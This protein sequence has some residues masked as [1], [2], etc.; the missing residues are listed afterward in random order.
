MSAYW[1]RRNIKEMKQKSILILGSEGFIGRHLVQ[2]FR[3]Q[4]W[5]VFGCDL[6]EAPSQD[7]KYQKVS[8]LSPELDDVFSGTYYFTCI[9]AAG[10][11]NVNYSMTHPVNDFEANCLDTIRVL[12][13]IK[14]YQNECRYLHFSSAAVYGNPKSLPV[15]E[16]HETAPLSPYGWHKVISE[17]LCKEYATIYKLKT[18]AVRPFSIY[19][20]GL[21]KQLLWDLYKKCMSRTDQDVQLWGTGN[22]SRDFLF[23]YDLIK[24]IDILVHEGDFNGGVYNVASG[25][26]TSIRH[27]TN[28][29]TSLFDKGIRITFNQQVREGDPI[30]W[31]ADITKIKSHNFKPQY[32][33]EQGLEIVVEWMKNLK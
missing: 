16:E 18:L 23:I 14:K 21:Q 29:F 17:H 28:L 9:N 22:E 26:E 25:E 30:N 7:Y 13:M 5:E 2:F 1:P 33:L 27:I 31:R 24:C 19:G 12:D 8:R 15:E 11:G 3:R 4:E 32:S 20:P 10:S 6:Y